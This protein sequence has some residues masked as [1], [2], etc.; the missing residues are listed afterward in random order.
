MF[1]SK[2]EELINIGYNKLLK[3]NKLDYLI[4]LS[5]RL[6]K[7]TLI[8]NRNAFN[9]EKKNFEK[10]VIQFLI[11]RVLYISF[12]ERIL[13][14]LGKKNRQCVQSKIFY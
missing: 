6:A 10:C 5:N 9:T 14:A 13:E 11:Q 8:V 4:K 7:Q 2:R 3:E 1:T 12:N